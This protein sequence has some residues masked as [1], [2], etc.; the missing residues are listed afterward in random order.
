MN[1]IQNSAVVRKTVPGGQCQ[2]K[3]FVI[4][5]VCGCGKST[6]AQEL[7]ARLN[8]RFIEADEF[9]SKSNIEKM[10]SG[11]PLTDEDRWPWLDALA[12]ELAKHVAKRESAV[13]ACS[14]LRK[15]YRAR[16]AGSEERYE[17][18]DDPIHFVHL[19]LDEDLIKARVDAREDHYMPSSLL[20]SQLATLEVDTNIVQ[21]D[22]SSRPSYICDQ[23]LKGTRLLK[24][25]GS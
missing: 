15:A 14:A 19:A 3:V 9:H 25:G 1:V 20:K 13:L 18:P 10:R 5:G 16:L 11:T 6:I 8:C 2:P 7:S 24:H 12:E 22:A 17:D 23:I 21:V 4:M